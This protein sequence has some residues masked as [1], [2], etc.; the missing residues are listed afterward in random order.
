MEETE[1]SLI[2]EDEKV[3]YMEET[4]IKRIFC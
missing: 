1:N 4:G 3:V 2:L